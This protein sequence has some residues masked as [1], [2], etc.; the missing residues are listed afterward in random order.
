MPKEGDMS[1]N[2]KQRMTLSIFAALLLSVIFISG[3]DSGTLTSGGTEV[4]NPGPVTFTSWDELETHI[5][6]EFT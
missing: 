3:C 1:L 4:G 6:N 5:K 2:I